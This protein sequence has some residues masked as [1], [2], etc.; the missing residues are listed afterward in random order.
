M[1]KT[2][3]IGTRN[4]GTQTVLTDGV[5]NIGSVYRKF[6]KTNSC[7]VPAFSRTSQ[8][9]TLQHQGIYHLTATFVGS[10]TEAGDVT[11]QL[12]VDGIPVDGVFSTQTITTPTTELRTFVIDYYIKV[13]KDCV[14]GYSSTDAETI[15]FLNTGVDATFTSV[16]VNVTKEV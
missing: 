1:N 4:I 14:L 7:G 8:D 5:I 2:L 11:I 12:V 10:G 6:C 3:L 16:V 15:S 9:L 13:D